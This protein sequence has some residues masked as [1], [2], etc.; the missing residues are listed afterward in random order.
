MHSSI[1]YEVAE[2]LSTWST[3]TRNDIPNKLIPE[4]LEFI[5]T[6]TY[7]LIRHRCLASTD[8][9]VLYVFF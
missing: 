4:K 7:N 5:K 1:I 8:V 3:H 2:I 6:V 9:E